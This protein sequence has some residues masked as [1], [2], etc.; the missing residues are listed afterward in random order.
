MKAISEQ[1]K[2][3]EHVFLIEVNVL[4]TVLL[5]RWTVA[6]TIIVTDVIVTF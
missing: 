6:G 3:R 1:P 5:G 2:C 4:G